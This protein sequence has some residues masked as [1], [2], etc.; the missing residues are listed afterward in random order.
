MRLSISSVFKATTTTLTATA[1]I[2]TARR[3]KSTASTIGCKEK[4][5]QNMKNL[6]IRCSGF[7]DCVIVFT[8]VFHIMIQEDPCGIVWVGLG[9][10]VCQCV[11]DTE[12]K[13]LTSPRHSWLA[14]HT[15][16]TQNS[17]W[18]SLG[19]HKTHHTSHF[20]EIYQRNK[21]N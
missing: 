5:L 18:G 11:L 19:R 6:I 7:S 13:P 15:R 10:M 1:T 17:E 9:D 12:K 4:H 8:W 14:L 2:S 21:E 3:T 16:T 20:L